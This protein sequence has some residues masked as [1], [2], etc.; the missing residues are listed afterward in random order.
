[1]ISDKTFA[2][3]FTSFWQSALPG[4][5][6]TVR[7]IN[8]SFKR[9]SPPLGSKSL[10]TRL[11]LINEIGFR[12]YKASLVENQTIKE[13]QST[14]VFDKI[15]EQALDFIKSFRENAEIEYAQP[16]KSEKAEGIEIAERLHLYF[17]VN[18]RGQTVLPSPYFKG[19]GFVDGCS[20]DFLVGD[21]L[22]EIKSGD[23]NFRLID[24]RQLLVCLALDYSSKQYNIYYAGFLNPR[25]GI[26]CRISVSDLSIRVSGKIPAELFADII[27][28]VSS[29]GVSH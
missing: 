25:V 26:Y 5:E 13:I 16:S 8:L 21:T 29:N 28:F 18:E 4:G 27:E 6:A 9:F 12:L 3:S 20:S 19:C 14:S 2:T 11:A 17:S 24:I 22:Y 23:R 10:A 1:M 7:G 15:C